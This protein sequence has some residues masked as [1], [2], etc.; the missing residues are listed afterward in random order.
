MLVSSIT[1]LP[2]EMHSEFPKIPRWGMH[3]VRVGS[4][5]YVFRDGEL[6]YK[7]WLDPR[8]GDKRQPSLLYN[9]NGWPNVWIQ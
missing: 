5:L 4:E 3:K 1:N 6:V 9:T 7:R 2:K 8:N